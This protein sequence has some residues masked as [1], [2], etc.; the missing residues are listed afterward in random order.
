MANKFGIGSV[1][2]SLTRTA[3][4]TTNTF[5]NLASASEALSIQAEKNAWLSIAKSAMETCEELG[6][7]AKTPLEALEATNAILTNLRGY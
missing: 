4:H 1:W 3:T 5:G 7:E 2:G 6:I